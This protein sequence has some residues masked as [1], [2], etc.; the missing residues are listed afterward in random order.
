MF[1]IIVKCVLALLFIANLFAQQYNFKIYKRVDDYNLNQILSIQQDDYGFLWIGSAAGLFRYDSETWLRFDVHDGLP[2]NIINALSEDDSSRL[3]VGTSLGLVSFRVT[4]NIKFSLDSTIH[5]PNKEIIFLHFTQGLL[6]VSIKGQGL[7][8]GQNGSFIPLTIPER[9]EADVFDMEIDSD[10]NLLIVLTDGRAGTV[11]KT[12]GIFRPVKISAGYRFSCVTASLNHSEFFFGTDR[13]LFRYSV[14]TEQMRPLYT[15]KEASRVFRIEEEKNGIIWA[16][17]KTGLIRILGDKVTIIRKKNGLPA[18]STYRLLLD[19][20]NNLWIG[21][22]SAGLA[23]LSYRNIFAYNENDGLKSNIVNCVLEMENRIKLIG[24][25]AGISAIK[26]NR[27]INDFRFGKLDDKVIWFIYEDNKGDIWAGGEDVLAVWRR[28]VKKLYFLHP[29]YTPFVILDMIQ[30]SNNR[31][32]FASTLGVFIYQNKKFNL[33]TEFKNHGITMVFDVEE[34]SNGD[35]LLGTDNGIVRFNGQ[36]FTYIGID[37]GL[38]DRSVF[39]IHEDR[40]GRIWLG[41]DLGLIEV[42]ENGFRLYGKNAG[43][44]GIIVTQ[45]LEDKDGVLWLCTERGL[46]KFENGEITFTLNYDDGLIGEE[47]TTQNSS[48]ID[49]QGL[50]W[51]GGF[52]GLTIYDPWQG[53]EDVEPKVYF[54]KAFYQEA[55]SEPVSFLDKERLE[56]PFSH[57]NLLFD[58]LGIYFRNEDVIS[59]WYKLDGIDKDWLQIGRAGDVRY[60]NLWPGIYHLKVKAVVENSELA[61]GIAEKTII[62][63]KPF[64]LTL[65]FIN[66]MVALFLLLGILILRARMQRMRRLYRQLEKKVAI[67]TRELAATKAFLE[68]IIEHVGSVIIAVDAKGKVTTWNKRAEHVFG[69]TRDEQ[70]GKM[71]KVLDIENDPYPFN[72]I[73]ESARDE[74]DLHQLEVKKRTK[75]GNTVELILNATSL[76]DENDAVYSITLAMEDFSERNR[77]MKNLIDQEK[78]MAGIG[79]LNRLLATLSHYFNNSIMAINGMAQLTRMDSKFSAK[80]LDTTESQIIRMQAVL[81]SLSDLVQRL[82]LKTRDYVGVSHQLFDIEKEIKQFLKSLR[83]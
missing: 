12:T 25:D 22:Y 69:Y 67:R 23:K 77:L 10:G 78:I 17:T 8:Y 19:R 66:L 35:I 55:E 63:K 42:L 30:D 48:I 16:A 74:G 64:Y 31:Y 45:I 34:I 20:E 79:A 5:F 54:K 51:L 56:I 52:G 50:F 80:F 4:K 18:N 81:K 57:R 21:T 28:N 71:L 37:E 33:L 1:K 43:L 76:H 72:A 62:I 3:W 26:E 60:N 82:N 29:T 39:E 58:F 14:N 27:F 9:K 70:M 41:C 75:N 53:V 73:L 83:K 24:T 68:N 61:S 11:N 2:S 49:E 7:Y 15:S 59:Y 13:G 44:K 36:K 40:N 46:H 38:P 6:W 47:F 65:W 32:W